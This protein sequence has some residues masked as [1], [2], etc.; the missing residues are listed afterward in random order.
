MENLVYDLQL[1]LVGF[2]S[3]PDLC[4]LGQTCRGLR[5]VCENDRLYGSLT[6]REFA[7]FASPSSSQ[8]SGDIILPMG[9]RWKQLYQLL[10]RARVS[11]LR[12]LRYEAQPPPYM[13]LN[14]GNGCNVTHAVPVVQLFANNKADR[15]GGSR[16]VLI[17]EPFHSLCSNSDRFFGE[18]AVL[19]RCT[20]SSVYTCPSTVSELQS[21]SIMCIAEGIV[22]KVDNPIKGTD[23]VYYQLVFEI[24]AVKRW[25]ENLKAQVALEREQRTAQLP[26]LLEQ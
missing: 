19:P 25:L 14:K 5:G 1:Y 16:H 21:V 24:E 12:H 20:R 6:R 22:Y 2:L 3:A 10:W 11:V 17:V 8:A 23:N 7:Q 18:K 13:F 26:A 4:R 15:D 9:W